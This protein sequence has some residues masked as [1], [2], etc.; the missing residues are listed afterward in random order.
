MM[1]FS[2]RVWQIAAIFL[3]IPS[4]LCLA[5]DDDEQKGK[6]DFLPVNFGDGKVYRFMGGDVNR[7]KEAFAKLNCNQCHHVAGVNDIPAPKG[8]RRLNLALAGEERFVK[9]YEDIITAITNPRHVIQEQYKAILSKA[10]IDGE[11]EPFMPDL[12]DFMTA[13]QLID[14][15]AFLDAAYDKKIESYVSGKD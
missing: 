14:L 4:L 13:K 12:T 11:V 15:T 1:K 9:R 3:W 7:G 5:A 8:K 10:E 2:K 6:A